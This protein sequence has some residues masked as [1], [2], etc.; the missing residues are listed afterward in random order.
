LG[1]THPDV[2]QTVNDLAGFYAAANDRERSLAYSRIATRAAIAGGAIKTINVFHRHVANLAA[3]AKARAE[4]AAV[5]ARE[6]LEIAQR[7]I[8]SSAGSALQQMSARFK[9]GSGELAGLARERQD[10]AAQWR[11]K[12]RRLIEALS[13]PESGQDSSAI[14]ALHK[15]IADIEVR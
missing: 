8:Q 15:D 7:A 2:A 9:E 4:P 12:D 3:A 10:L 6:A 5:L 13:K 11:D 1:G 14:E